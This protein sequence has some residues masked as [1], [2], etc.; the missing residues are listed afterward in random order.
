MFVSDFTE[1][2]APAEHIAARLA[3]HAWDGL[4]ASERID[5]GAPRAR[6]DATLIPIL[7]ELRDDDGAVALLVGDL[8]VAP[9]ERSTCLVTLHASYTSPR[10]RDHD[11]AGRRRVARATRSALI[12]LVSACA[13][14]ELT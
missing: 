8:E 4:A 7:W 1:L 10:R 11:D 9:L 12:R 14:E 5:V 3:G 6:G 13:V 2:N